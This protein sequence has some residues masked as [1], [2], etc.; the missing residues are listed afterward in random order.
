MKYRKKPVIVEA[1]QYLGTEDWL[2]T[3]PEEFKQV[4]KLGNLKEALPPYISTLEGDMVIR[5][6]D[7]VIKGVAGEFYSCRYD[8][9]NQT[10]E[11]VD[12]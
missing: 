8:I 10:Y 1:H 11:A 9:F 3:A 2:L 5:L 4:V 6:G 7:Y 12:V